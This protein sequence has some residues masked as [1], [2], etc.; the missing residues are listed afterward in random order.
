M[1]EEPC[2]SNVIRKAK[3]RILPGFEKNATASKWKKAFYF[4]QA[5]DTQLGMIDSWGDGSV[6]S[7]YPNITWDREIELCSQT[8]DLLNRMRPRPAFFIVCGDL[9]DAFPDKWPEIRAAQEKDF[10]KV[11]QAQR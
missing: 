7:H 10:F 9:V 1:E 8:V 5:A 11:T 2:S 4:V 6:G 3:E